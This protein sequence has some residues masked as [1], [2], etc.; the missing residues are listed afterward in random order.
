MIMVAISIEVKQRWWLQRKTFLR[1]IPECWDDVPPRR[2]RGF[3]RLLYSQPINTALQSIAFSILRI[4]RRWRRYLDPLHIA[5]LTNALAWM[6]PKADCTQAVITEFR[7]RGMRWWMPAPK[8]SDINCIQYLVAD[9]AFE[10][11]GQG[12][13]KSIALLLAALVRPYPET[14]TSAPLSTRE[15][16][17]RRALML[18]TAPEEVKVYALLYFAGLKAYIHRSY[19][20]W[21]FVDDA[22]EEGEEESEGDQPPPRTPEFGWYGILQDV[23]ESGLFGTM[24]QVMLTGLHDVLVYLVRQTI[25]T[26]NLNLA[27]TTYRDHNE[28]E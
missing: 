3:L 16:A 23:A 10:Q 26:E 4:P 24:P 11:A 15:E 18:H 14:D 25:K 27:R 17:E 8:G 13:G 6:E 21:L 2:R 1:D 5:T 19:K 9:D 12:H 22:Q 28:A 20:D 7:H